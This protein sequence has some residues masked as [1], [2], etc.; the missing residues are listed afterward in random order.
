MRKLF[1]L[2]L[3]VQSNDLFYTKVQHQE[4]KVKIYQTIVTSNIVIVNNNQ[5]KLDTYPD[6][7][8]G[9]KLNLKLYY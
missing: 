2:S 5:I 4:C 6:F 3:S 1:P 8:K 9:N 7:L